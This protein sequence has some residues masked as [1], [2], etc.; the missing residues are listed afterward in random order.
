MAWLPSL[1]SLII[2]IL[3]QFNAAEW[4]SSHPNV[5][6]GLGTLGTLIT[7][8]VKSPFQSTPEPQGA[9][10]KH[11]MFS[12][13]ILALAVPAFMVTACQP[14]YAFNATATGA[15]VRLSYNEPTQNADNTPLRDLSKTTGYWAAMPNGAPLACVTTVASAPT[16][17]GHIEADCTVPVLAG[18]EADIA[19][20]V[21]AS[22]KT[23]NESRHTNQA[24][25]RLD[26]LSPASPE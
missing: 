15:V 3:G 9:M 13:F 23:G 17:G 8:L 14:A 26:F 5:A 12:F 1:I 7:A 6:M 21:T 18:Q 2:G 24:V 10:G 16:G 19:F 4:V 25:L 22:D 11:F 20:T